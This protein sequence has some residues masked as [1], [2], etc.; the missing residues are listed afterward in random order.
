MGEMFYGRAVAY[1][2]ALDRDDAGALEAAVA[3]NVFPD[4]GDAHNIS[5]LARYCRTA[6]R[7]LDGQAEAVLLKG[8]VRFPPPEAESP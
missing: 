6:A 2:E 8:D 5:A 7:L 1:G 3:R 4:G